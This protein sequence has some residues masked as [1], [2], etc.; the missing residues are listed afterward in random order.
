MLF[1]DCLEEFRLE[2]ILRKLSD[3]TVTSYYNNSNLFLCYTLK[4]FEEKK[5]QDLKPLHIKKYVQYLMSKK[6]KTSYINSVLKC[7]RAFF[8]Y[9]IEEEYITENPCEKV[10]WQREGKVVIQTFTDEEVQSLMQA[11]D[12]STFLSTRNKLILGIAFDTGARNS[13]ICAI[14]NYDI[15]D[16]VILLHGKGNKERQVPITPYLKKL[17]MKYERIKGF[18]FDDRKIIPDNYLLSRT[19][20]PLTKE[21]IER[22]FNQANEIANV[23][24]CIRCSPHTARH[25]YA[26]ANLRHGLD[27][28]SLSRL[29]GH[30]SISITK[31]YLQSIQDE[32]IVDM[33][34]NS[35]P[36]MHIMQ[37]RC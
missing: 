6:L 3:R 18:Y 25:Y 15:R 21:A 12:F 28:Y 17:M 1:M 20:K 11:F 4:H 34:S 10:R 27:V 7:L 30:E 26:Q 22:V 19:G 23:R 8:K 31:R 2:C 14:K 24:S 36:L 37:E 32:N 35:S 9:A 13:E 16:H 5:V 33:A 29:L